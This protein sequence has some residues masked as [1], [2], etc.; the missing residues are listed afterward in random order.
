MELFQLSSS[1]HKVC[2]MVTPD[3]RGI[4]TSGN[5]PTKRGNEGFSRQIRYKLEMDSLH[6]QTNK[7]ANVSLD[8]SGFP[9]TPIF[10]LEWTSVVQ[11]DPFKKRGG[12]Y[13]L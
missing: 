3:E 11:T 7:Q 10:D 2:T 13:S 8:Y 9:H 1:A 5:E 6:G 12:H 4:A